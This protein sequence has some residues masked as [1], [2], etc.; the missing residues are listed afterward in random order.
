MIFTS[1]LS[2]KVLPI[3]MR[4]LCE[5]KRAFPNNLNISK[6]HFSRLRTSVPLV[7]V[8]LRSTIRSEVFFRDMRSFHEDEKSCMHNKNTIPTS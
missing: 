6:D 1:F 4:L 8:P 5:G 2:M 7:Q 3:T